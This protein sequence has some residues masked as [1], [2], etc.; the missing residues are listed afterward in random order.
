[1]TDL[2]DVLTKQDADAY[3]AYDSS[4][5]ADMRYLA[6]F[7]ASDPYIYVYPRGGV[8]TLIVSS[9]E[10]LRARR[11]SPCRVI[12]R[13]AAGLPGLLKEHHDADLA[14]AHMIR[15][16]AG[17][18]L[19][20]PASMPIGFAQ[21]LMQVAEVAVDKT[22]V[23]ALRRIKTPEE[24]KLI[25][26]VQLH[27]ETATAAAVA[28]IRD[29][30][31]DDDG[32][33]WQGRPL[34]AERVRDEIAATLRPFDCEE[35][36]TIISC[37]ADTALPHARGAGQL[38]AHEPIVMDVFPKSL[39]TGYFADMTRTVARGEPADEIVALYATVKKAKELAASMLGPGVSG[40][41]VHSAVVA[42][43]EEQGYMTAGSSGFI[44]GLGHGVGLQIHEA[45]P[46]SPTG[47]VLEPGNVITVEP[48]LYYPGIGGVRLE[49][50]GVITE[51]G[52]DRFTNFEEQL[53]L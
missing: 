10:E 50:M 42:F 2:A 3:V 27:N 29:A 32:L 53:L 52:F 48:G 11:E 5:N 24:I 21:T 18:K 25:R 4:E 40:A 30:D 36:D 12:T 41:D 6:G 15:T 8:G 47:G 46:L 7:L 28:L 44:H 37:G 19:L 17:E 14:T 1:M 33:S 23:A 45:P 16:F 9:M 34:T 31:I 51:T 43:F 38:R 49:D 35:R 20:V 39:K 22:T 26:Q 13:S